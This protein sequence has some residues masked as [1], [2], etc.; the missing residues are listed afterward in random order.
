LLRVGPAYAQTICLD[1]TGSAQVMADNGMMLFTG[2][3]KYEINHMPDGFKHELTVQKE[4]S[5]TFKICPTGN[6]DRFGNQVVNILDVKEIFLAP[7]FYP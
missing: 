1:A 6:H 4:L 7:V 2:K 3:T 5:G